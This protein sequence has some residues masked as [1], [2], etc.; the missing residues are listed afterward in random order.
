[1]APVGFSRCVTD[2]I[3]NREDISLVTIALR[4]LSRFN[5]ISLML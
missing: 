5:Y 4:S 2:C 1:M 3:I